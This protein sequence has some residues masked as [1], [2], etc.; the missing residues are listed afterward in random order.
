MIER[1]N[2][3]NGQPLEWMVLDSHIN[4][5]AKNKQD[6]FVLKCLCVT[7]DISI[8]E[9][10]YVVGGTCPALEHRM[11]LLQGNGQKPTELFKRPMRFYAN[12][13][14]V[15][16]GDG[17]VRW[18]FDPFTFNN[19]AIQKEASALDVDMV[20]QQVIARKLSRADSLHELERHGQKFVKRYRE[21]V[22]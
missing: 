19:T 3:D 4:T 14:P 2:V 21:L 22:K 10:F 18:A 7:Y 6:V 1:P 15:M 9:R 17:Y 16:E 5:N 12:I 13:Y 20:V 8:T 11:S